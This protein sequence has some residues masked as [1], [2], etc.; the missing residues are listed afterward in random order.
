MAAIISSQCKIRTG[1]M[2]WVLLCCRMTSTTDV[3]GSMSLPVLQM[4]TM[5]CYCTEESMMTSFFIVKGI[6]ND[7]IMVSCV[8]YRVRFFNE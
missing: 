1:I 8:L 6:K 3:C 5:F 4:P 7:V 2:V